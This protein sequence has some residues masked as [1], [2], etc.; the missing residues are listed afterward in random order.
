MSNTI[1]IMSL[2]N[3][4]KRSRESAKSLLGTMYKE[5]TTEDPAVPL[6]PNDISEYDD[7]RLKEGLH[8]ADQSLR[9]TTRKVSPV[10]QHCLSL[11]KSALMGVLGEQY[12]DEEEK[13][14][15]LQQLI[16]CER[17]IYNRKFLRRPADNNEPSLV[18]RLSEGRRYEF[19]ARYGDYMARVCEQIKTNAKVEKTEHFEKLYSWKRFWTDINHNLNQEHKA[20]EQWNLR[21]PGV[22]LNNVKTTLAVYSS[23]ELMALNFDCAL[24]A[25][26]MYADRNNLVHKSITNL[27]DQGKWTVLKETLCRDLADIPAVTPIHLRGNI[28]VLQEIMQA[29]VDQYFK[30]DEDAPNNPALWVPKKEALQNATK[31][32]EEQASRVARNVAERQSIEK[33]AAKRYEELLK[34]HSMV[35]L[36]AALHSTDA[37][38]GRLPE[39]SPRKRSLT[40]D[41]TQESNER[42]KRQKKAWHTMVEQQKRCLQSL[43]SYCDEFGS[44]EATVP[45]QVW[46]D[47]QEEDI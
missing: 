6:P 15:M 20:W 24:Q 37:P 16:M 21:I 40:Q 1:D 9:C 28:P 23:C 11:Y 42:F 39:R 4:K 18:Q 32:D 19:A 31:R 36:A 33:K 26:A 43:E 27:A 5:D 34:D 17:Q 10:G 22:S 13:K 7:E 8:F 41:D 30:R 46:L 29:V 44:A 35:H 12:E 38:E 3:F 25:I 14:D 2:S 47:L 45:P